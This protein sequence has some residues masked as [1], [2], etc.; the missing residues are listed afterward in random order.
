MCRKSCLRWRRLSESIPRE[1]PLEALDLADR[2]ERKRY[3]TRLAK[4]PPGVSGDTKHLEA[5]SKVTIYGICTAT[6]FRVIAIA[7]KFLMCG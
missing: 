5:V 7:S 6:I 3:A 1:P 2:A 4:I